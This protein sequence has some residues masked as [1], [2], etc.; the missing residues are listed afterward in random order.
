MKKKFKE[1]YGI[2]FL[3]FTAASSLIFLNVALDGPSDLGPYYYLIIIVNSI[4]L[5]ALCYLIF[6]DL[7]KLMRRLHKKEAGAKL[8]LRMLIMF[9]VFAV[10]PVSILYSFSLHS[11][12]RSIDSWFDI[13]IS[14]ALQNSLELGRESLGMLMRNYRRETETLAADL[15]KRKTERLPLDLT[16]LRDPDGFVV[17]RYQFP[18]TGLIDR[19]RKRSKAEEVLVL[20]MEGQ[21]VSASSENASL[22]PQ[23][24]TETLLLQ[25]NDQRSF[26]GLEP[27]NS[28]QLSVRV[29]LNIYLDQKRHIL[30]AIYPF[31]PRI[32]NLAD[33][34]ESGFAKY[35]ELG[36]LRDKLKISF[37]ITLTLVLLFSVA[38]SIWAAFFCARFLTL[39]ISEL[40]H[41]TSAIADGN[42]DTSVTVKGDDDLA[43]LARSFNYM[44]KKIALSTNEIENQRNY[45]D[46]VMKQLSSGV[47]TLSDK[48]EILTINRAAVALF[49]IEEDAAIGKKLS[50]LSEN[51]SNLS[52]FF[53]C[54]GN[55]LSSD[56]KTWE[57]N[58]CLN[59]SD[60]KKEIMC[61]GSVLSEDNSTRINHIIVLED[62][63]AIIQGQ[64]DAAWAE[65]AKRLAHEIKNPLT[66]IKLS[67]ERLLF[68][69]SDKL[70]KP[71]R[72]K[73]SNLSGT[74]IEQVE[75][76]TEMVDEFSG[77][78]GRNFNQPAPLDLN[79]ILT[80]TAQL[81]QEAEPSLEITLQKTDELPQIFGDANSLRRLFNNLIKNSIEASMLNSGTKI[82]ISAKYPGAASPDEIEISILDEG[83]GI[84]DQVLQNIFEPY[85]TS[86]AR[87]R[88]LGLAIVKKIV[89]E[90]NGTIKL[91]N[92]PRQGAL[93]TVTLP[94]QRPIGMSN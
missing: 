32:D 51:N 55:L 10:L 34:V 50:S 21:V 79:L 31:S 85:V 7:L 54:T 20:T 75:T 71:D 16:S 44:T 73:L 62:I 65:M 63:S 23:L 61:K 2:Y 78:A 86:K 49:Q 93:V 82:L 70:K 66:P 27:G 92:A 59:I 38:A 58:V 39:P 80:S 9:V 4:C 40:S 89:E 37:T 74:I 41:A 3:L 22:L 24:P 52:S 64:R 46:A 35:N 84:A 17:S 13:E 33:N 68:K 6:I 47:I 91:E 1:K 48:L 11:I 88:G 43:S 53:E 76:M 81:F 56:R 14:T 60:N 77:Y 25:L 45:L 90:H 19:L 72:E 67:A 69:L 12:N 87:G 30:Q 42:Y 57:A 29:A 83:I 36:F 26:I 15:T 5:C 28:G 8:T 94:V 18:S